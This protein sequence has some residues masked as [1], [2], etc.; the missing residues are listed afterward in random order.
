LIKL[1]Y[2]KGLIGGKAAKHILLYLRDNIVD[3]YTIIQDLFKHLTS[4]YKNPNWLFITKNKFKKLFIKL[5]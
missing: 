1:A 3:L 5:T 4:A 2:V